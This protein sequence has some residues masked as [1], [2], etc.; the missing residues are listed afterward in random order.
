VSRVETQMRQFMKGFNELVSSSMLAIFDEN[1]LEVNFFIF[2]DCKISMSY[3]Y[4]HLSEYYLHLCFAYTCQAICW[5]L[6]VANSQ[7]FHGN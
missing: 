1:E 4:L 2:D 7:R 3:S 6:I 5:L